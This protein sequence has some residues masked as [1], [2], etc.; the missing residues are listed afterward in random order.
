MNAPI[1]PQLR[2]LLTRITPAAM[3]GG[4]NQLN[5]DGLT[6]D[7]LAAARQLQTL[8]ETLNKYAAAAEAVISRHPRLGLDVRWVSNVRGNVGFMWSALETIAGRVGR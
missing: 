7:D 2:Q 8:A 6:A 3:S 1:T 5:P 4:V